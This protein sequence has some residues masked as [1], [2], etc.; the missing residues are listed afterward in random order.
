M[1]K[2]LWYFFMKRITY[3]VVH[4]ERRVPFQINKTGVKL[5]TVSFPYEQI[6]RFGQTKYVY[7]FVCFDNH[8]YIL[9]TSKAT[10]IYDKIY[11]RCLELYNRTIPLAEEVDDQRSELLPNAL[12]VSV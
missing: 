7:K 2:N 5:N 6:T 9:Y 10:Q 8:E 1:F 11:T 12:I 3:K 4:N